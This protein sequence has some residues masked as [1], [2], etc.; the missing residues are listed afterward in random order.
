LT[1]MSGT[2]DQADT[3]IT[4]LSE[5]IANGGLGLVVQ[6]SAANNLTVARDSG[7]T[8]VSLDGTGGARTVSGVNAGEVSATSDQAVNGGQLLETRRAA[9]E[10]I[11]A[12]DVLADAV[13]RNRDELATLGQ[14]VLRISEQIDMRTREMGALA[15]D[16]AGDVSKATVA[17]GSQGVAVGTGASVEGSNGIA[18][19]AGASAEAGNSVALG[20]GSVADR[21]SS[22]SVGSAGQERQIIHVANAT[23]ATDAVNLR[24]ALE[25][26]QATAVAAEQLANA[27]TDR[28]VDN[29]RSDSNAGITVAMAMAALPGASLP[30]KG[31]AAIGGA[32]YQGES[33]LALGISKMSDDGSW[34]Y[35]ASGSRNSQGTMGVSVGISYRW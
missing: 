21:E 7:G 10:N 12:T 6:D 1:E 4:T 19:G 24:Q 30:G 31:M 13:G 35:K 9:G 33:A 27:Y 17:P 29:L 15:I 3:H 16:I 23:A 20:E 18:F 5:R 2:I 22:V 8:R 11:A 26:T 14:E 25:I 28:Q 32:T 34:V